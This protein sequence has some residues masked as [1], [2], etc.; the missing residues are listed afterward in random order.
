M[1]SKLH[2]ENYVL[3]DSLDIAFPEGLVIITGETGAGKSILL[4]ALSLALGAK[5]DAAAIGP[6]G[7]TCVVEAEFDVEEDD[8][9]RELFDEQDLDAD[10]GHLVIR[11][12]VARTGRSRS[13]VNDLPVPVAVLQQLSRR[14][15]DIH[16]QHETRLLSDRAWQL[17]VLDHFAGNAAL[18]SEIRAVH[19]RLAALRRERAETEEKLRRMAAE[20]DFNQAQLDRLTEAKLRDGEL[21]ELEEEQRRLANAGE[22]KEGLGRVGELFSPPDDGRMSLD[23]LLKEAGRTLG[24][25]GKFV[26]DAE[27]L[28]E[29]IESARL[30]LEDIYEE[31]GRLDASVELSEDRLTQVEERLSLL[32][33]L[34]KKHACSDVG[35][36]I[37]LRDALAGSLFE[38]EALEERIADLDREI[39]QAS[40]SYDALAAGLRDARVKAA[41]AFAE[42]ITHSLRTLELEQA[43]FDAAVEPAADGASGRDTVLFRFSAT[44]GAPADVARC[45]SGGEMSRIMLSLKA[46]MAR[47][48]DMPTLVFDEIDTGVSGSAADRMGDLIAAMGAV[49]QGFAITHLPQVAAKGGAHYLVTK[50]G[51]V[52]SIRRIE[53]ADRVREVARM[54]SGSRITEAALENART[55]LNP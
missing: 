5:A 18:R 30:E 41:P 45:A 11:R 21:E 55:L 15:I 6:H 12:T 32:Y 47:Y 31:V 43:V 44:G 4:G 42:A 39:G 7:E 14:L 26:P 37:S 3:I 40:S 54:L 25:V 2:V 53:G 48:T 20:R 27:P 13:F 33:G 19:G 29:R 49:M 34:L 8:A 17:D 16:S 38:G 23:A 52:T 51:A 50:A 10:G 22:I 36:L 24:R 1:L 35:G 9:L 28:R 46:M